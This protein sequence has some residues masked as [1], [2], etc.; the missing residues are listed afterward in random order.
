MDIR[1]AMPYA[2]FA[3]VYSGLGFL[4][5][6]VL[7]YA[8]PEYHSAIWEMLVTC[9]VA[10]PLGVLASR[11]YGWPTY[12][13]LL[14]ASLSM[15]VAEYLLILGMLDMIAAR[16]DGNL[17]FASTFRSLSWGHW[18]ATSLQ[19]VAPLLWLPVLKRYAAGGVR[20]V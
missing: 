15:I 17:N 4:F 20:A 19:L 2:A 7:N 3:V 18:L 14:L 6:V 9:L 10:A 16:N 13:G 12:M 5:V 1:S 8:L 11:R